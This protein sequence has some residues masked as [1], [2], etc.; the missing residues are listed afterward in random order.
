MVFLDIDLQTY[1]I[2]QMIDLQK[3][4][5]KIFVQSSYEYASDKLRYYDQIINWVHYDKTYKLLSFNCFKNGSTT[6]IVDV[7]NPS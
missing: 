3:E 6:F 4:C 7:M 5:S 1:K 2:N